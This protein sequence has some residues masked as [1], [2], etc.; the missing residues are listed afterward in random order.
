MRTMSVKAKMP[1]KRTRESAR[2]VMPILRQRKAR[3]ACHATSPK[4]NGSMTQAKMRN[5]SGSEARLS[6]CQSPKITSGRRKTAASMRVRRATQGGTRGRRDVVVRRGAAS[7]GWPRSCVSRCSAGRKEPRKS[8]TRPV[9][10]SAGSLQERKR[11]T[12]RRSPC[13]RARFHSRST[14]GERMLAGVATTTTVCAS[15]RARSISWPQSPPGE[16]WFASSQ[17]SIPRSARWKAS[18]SAK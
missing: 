16:R 14:W 12:S 17:P 4:R 8:T 5:A 13:A 18:D 11:A 3:Q 15:S 6:P 9:R 1:V 7:G 10:S 2:R